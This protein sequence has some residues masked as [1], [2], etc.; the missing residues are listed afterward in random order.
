MSDFKPFAS[1]VHARY[2][3]LA[4]NELFTTIPGDKLWE[5]YLA[6][7]PEGTNPIFR[8]N[9]EHDCSC[10]RNF[11]K[12]L[13]GVVSIEGGEV[14]TVWGVTGLTGTYAI[15]A[16]AL[17]EAVK[18]WTITGVFRSSEHSYG[19]EMTRETTE[20]GTVQW[21]HFHGKVAARHHTKEVG[22]IVGGLNTTA[23]VF[24]RGLEELTIDALETV[25]GLIQSN[26]LYRGTEH[27]PAV[28]NFLNAKKLFDKQ[29]TDT[30]KN[31]LVWEN[32]SAPATRFRN[33][34]IGTLVQD[35]SAGMDLEAAVRSFEVKVAPTNYKRTTALVTPAMVKDAMKTIKELDLE[36]A[37]ERRFARISDVSV[38]NVL[39]VDNGVKGQMKGGIEDLLLGSVTAKA[40]AKDQATPITMAEFL[41]SVVP[42]AQGI[43]LLVS[44]THASNFMSLTAPQ[45]AGVKQLFK[46]DNDFAWSYD[47]NITD[48]I[49]ERVKAA[50][51]NVT[52]AKLRVSLA[53]HN[54]D[55]LDL[56]AFE[57]D[58][59]HVYFGN[60]QGKLDVDMNA[61]GGR[62]RSP[63]ENISWT[64]LRDG[65]YRIKVDQFSKR[66]S[67]DVG[68]ELQ[69]QCGDQVH[70]FTHSAGLRD[71][72]ECQA[73]TITIRGGQIVDCKMGTGIVG[74]SF[75]QEK[76]GIQTE[77]FT[78][79]NALMKSPNHW[80]DNQAG[81]LHW[82]FVLDGCRNDMPTRGIYNEF[83]NS[84]LE[85]HRKVFELL[86]DKTKCPTTDDQL[87]GLG[88]SSTRNDSAQ[89]RVTTGKTTRLYNLSF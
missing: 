29:A 58:G 31:L 64:T 54:Y 87:S 14:K 13:G 25:L 73:L 72:A 5:F 71:K 12:N 38:N 63:V 39:W 16:K 46:W 56:H 81:N 19:A 49:K 2:N 8:T 17:D 35:L 62:S 24:R 75:S 11:V 65:V 36:A 88:F 9:T 7:F 55:D 50:G 22:T 4:K 68:F 23:H 61:G 86:G 37:L 84:R 27:L 18:A 43:E 3:E 69:V 79:V 26:N 1:K 15:V 21:N 60:K 45:H 28:Q 82:M 44:N 41:T 20:A 74:G 53:W 10:C 83:L 30:K 66:E 76:W 80:D 78:K 34:A 89:V 6:S 85:K 59:S 57:P 47:G 32:L 70:Q 33:T 67:S 42:T 48:A 40:P 77:K 52:T 51:G